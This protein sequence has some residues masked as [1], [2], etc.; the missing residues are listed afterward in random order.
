MRLE[1]IEDILAVL[2]CGSLARAAEKRLLTQSAF[3]RRVQM[4]E[5]SIGTTLF[6][7]HRKPVTL[8]PGVQA[9]EP[10]LRHVSGRL[11]KLRHALKASNDQAGK[12][13]A[14]VCQ[15]ALTTTISPRVVR[16]L[17]EVGETSVQVHSGNQD[18]CLMRLVSGAADFSIMYAVP[19]D[20]QPEPSNAFEALTLGTDM[21]IP[22]CAPPIRAL[23]RGAAFPVINYPP[24]VYL[25]QIFVRMINPRLP[26]ATTALPVV[27]TALTLAMLQLALNEIGVAWLPLSLVGRHLEQGR[28]V[29]LDDILPAHALIIR[30]LRM[31][32]DRTGRDDRIWQHLSCS[33]QFC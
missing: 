8:M 12:S 20:L 7:R 18:E 6:D 5:N 16:A 29:R 32:K 10:E 14:F 28:L 25:G 23:V 33:V 21:L 1:W 27:E 24:E 22:V 15:H 30:M 4:I 9:L 11:H 2:D 3:T 26:S 13:L 31:S 17:T 19:E